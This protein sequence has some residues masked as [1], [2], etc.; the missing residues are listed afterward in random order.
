M[1]LFRRCWQSAIPWWGINLIGPLG[2]AILGSFEPVFSIVLA[3]L[4]LGERLWPLQVA[5]G[6]LI[7]VGMFLVQWHPGGNG[8]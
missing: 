7:L 6:V 1:P 3:V 2:L 5:G 4:L 8:K